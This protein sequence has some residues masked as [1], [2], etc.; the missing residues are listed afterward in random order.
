MSAGRVLLID[1]Y[2]SF[3]HT[4]TQYFACLGASTTVIRTGEGWSQQVKRID[5]DLVVLGPGPGRPEATEYVDLLL[6]P[7]MENR[8]VLGVCLGHQAVGLAF[9]CDVVRAPEVRHGKQ[10]RIDHD[11]EG[12]FS[13][14]PQS[15]L[16]V[17]YHSLVTTT[18]S[19]DSPLVV[20]ARSQ[21]DSQVMGLRHRSRPIQSIQFHPESIASAHGA[22]IFRKA[23]TNATEVSRAYH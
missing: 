10:S 6:D 17:R 22:A 14:I 18:P 2:D 4:I 15:F 21:D 16:A 9:G 19:L 3:I 20:S 11:G 23:L 1:A 8:P 5:P 7:G 13:G 12:C